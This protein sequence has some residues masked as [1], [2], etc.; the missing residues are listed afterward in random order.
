MH[1]R[2]QQPT[3]EQ[4][5]ARALARRARKAANKG[6]QSQAKRLYQ[7]AVSS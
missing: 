7:L 1:N 4:R 5:R 2:S 6:R 3:Q